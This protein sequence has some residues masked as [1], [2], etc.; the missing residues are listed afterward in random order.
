[1]VYLVPRDVGSVLVSSTLCMILGLF[2]STKVT[3]SGIDIG[4]PAGLG[5]S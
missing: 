2:G 1:M 5:R 3:I 4:F